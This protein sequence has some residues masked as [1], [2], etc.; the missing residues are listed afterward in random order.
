MYK[1]VLHV[2][3]SQFFFHIIAHVSGRVTYSAEV[4]TLFYFCSAYTPCGL[5][6]G[7]FGHCNRITTFDESFDHPNYFPLK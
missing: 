3:T 2:N 1:C 5:H 6:L 4:F 7:P